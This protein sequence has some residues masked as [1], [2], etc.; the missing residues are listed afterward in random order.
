[1]DDIG[2]IGL[3]LAW[4][5]RHVQRYAEPSLPPATAAPDPSIV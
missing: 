5:A 2:I 3:V 1:M 4:T